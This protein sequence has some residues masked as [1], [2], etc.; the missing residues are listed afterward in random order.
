MCRFGLLKVETH[1]VDAI[2]FATLLGRSVIKNMSQVP[3]AF[4]AV[5]LGASHAKGIVWAGADILRDHRI[6]EG[7]PAGSGIKFCI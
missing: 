6:G 2:A 4:L 5:H 7:G 1:G 3:A